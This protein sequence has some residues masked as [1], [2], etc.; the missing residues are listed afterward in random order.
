MKKFIAIVL[1]LFMLVPGISYGQEIDLQILINLIIQL[2]QQIIALQ[3]A[4]MNNSNTFNV[5]SSQ[6]KYCFY[7]N[8]KY[9]Q[10]NYM[11][12][13]LQKVIGIQDPT[14]YFGSQTL[15]AV[16]EYQSNN[17]IDNTGYVGPLTRK[18]L[19]DEFCT[20]YVA[21][22]TVTTSGTTVTTVAGETTTTT[23]AEATDETTTTT[24]ASNREGYL[25]AIAG[26]GSV[27]SQLSKDST[28]EVVYHTILEAHQS[29]IT[30]HRVDIKMTTDDHQMPWHV[31]DSLSLATE[32]GGT[33]ISTIEIS[34]ENIIT[35]N[36]GRD[37]TVR[38]NDLDLDITYGSTQQLFVQA[39]A[40]FPQTLET[41]SFSLP[42]NAIRYSDELG[43]I[44]YAPTSGLSENEVSLTTAVLNAEVELIASS[45]NTERAV[46]I[47][48]NT[49]TENVPAIYFSL[50]NGEEGAVTLKNLSF[51]CTTP[52]SEISEIFLYQG[53]TLIDSEYY[54]S[55]VAFAN[56]DHTLPAE[57]SQDFT[58]KYTVKKD[59][60]DTIYGCTLAPSGITAITAG[61]DTIT[62]TGSTVTGGHLH[63]FKVIPLFAFV[64]NSF[65][66]VPDTSSTEGDASVTFKITA[67]GGTL[68]LNTLAGSTPTE[69]FIV[70][71]KNDS[72]GYSATITD[73][74]VDASGLSSSSENVKYLTSGS[75]GN[76]VISARITDVP[77]TGYYY[78][79][80]TSVPFGS[81]TSGT[82]YQYNYGI[83]D[84][85]TSSLYM[86]E[87][88]ND[89]RIALSGSNEN[90]TV[91]LDEG[92]TTTATAMNFTLSNA[93]TATAT[94]SS[95]D[96]TVPDVDYITSVKLFNGA[97]ELSSKSY[98]TSVSFNNLSFDVG[99]EGSATLTAK[100]ILNNSLITEDTT[101]TAIS[102]ATDDIVAYKPDETQISITGDNVSGGSIFLD[103]EA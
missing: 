14:G 3:Q 47:N 20:D 75:Y 17:G 96:V 1:C 10:R 76:V 74:A 38:F 54:T 57:T 6:E 48:D 71:L 67:S 43:L 92:D 51:T 97:T 4:R 41:I 49:A 32:A 79:D 58:V 98:A 28:S 53:S 86:Y 34:E 73:Y 42:G 36:Y 22:T 16:K 12:T 46:E 94:V 93:G 87:E 21:E 95:I 7:S 59:A 72:A 39:D 70:K 102:V 60:T 56:I 37:Y 19:N 40:A 100:Y 44:G 90:S 82:G 88:D 5:T 69:N 83:T 50:S 89:A 61:E 63:P 65:A 18:A 9:G 85:K 24:S 66:A 77:S 81:D 30:V 15:A 62:A 23:S 52:S 103:I 25:T 45:S 68:Y 78:M 8:L 84:I 80:I 13:K 33:A 2:Q 64:T 101:L 27:V 91:V 29:N 31:L 99:G 35:N 55:G 26:A 11:V